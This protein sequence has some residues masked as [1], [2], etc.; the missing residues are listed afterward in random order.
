ML[1]AAAASLLLLTLCVLPARGSQEPALAEV[2]KRAA[3]YVANFQKQLSGIV[4]EETYEQHI[5]KQASGDPLVSRRRL[6]SDLLLVRPVGSGRYVEF[7]DVFE[8]DGRAVRDR[9]D[10]LTTLFLDPPPG[11]QSQPERVASESARF[12]I[13]RVFRTMNT[14]VL[15]LA[16]LHADYQP[17]FTFTLVR[18]P[19]TAAMA[20]A[21]KETGRPTLVRTP[22]GLDM[23]ARG[24]FWVDTATGAVT[25]SEFIVEDMQVKATVNVTY[26]GDEDLAFLVPVE[27]REEYVAG[28]DVIE[29]RATYDRFRKFQVNVDEQIKPVK[30]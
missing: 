2:L 7:R 29:G 9:Q 26:R 17:Q 25:R 28:R 23:P 18:D 1:R 15:P 30:Q 21:F 22:G 19:A 3:L 27:M 6:K 20:I 14:P 13:G 24:R 8:V 4:A 16:F 11:A 5:K 10:R 12:N